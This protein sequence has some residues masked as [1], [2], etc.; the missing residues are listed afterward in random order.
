MQEAAIGIRPHSGWGAVVVIAGSPGAIAL[1]DRRKIVIT[2]PRIEG[3]RQPYHFAAGLNL[4]DA[5]RYIA[6]CAEASENLAV[7][8][9]RETVEAARRRGMLV[10]SCALLLA[11][12]RN[13]PELEKILAA[14]PLLHSAEGEF[15]RQ[16]FRGAGERLQLPVEGIRERDLDERASMLFGK[17]ADSVKREIAGLGRSAG[18]PWTTDQKNACLAALLV[19]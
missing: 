5:E 10:A 14:H 2:A 4:P 13:L 1:I 8:A 6:R 18:P 11:A 12:G 7:E 16:C 3:A 15:F 9:L 17:Q 19:L